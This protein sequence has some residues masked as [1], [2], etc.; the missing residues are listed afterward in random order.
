M[1]GENRNRNEG[2]VFQRTHRARVDD[3]DSRN[4]ALTQTPTCCRQDSHDV[5][6]A[7]TRTP[8]KEPAERIIRNVPK[9]Y[10]CVCGRFGFSA[11]P[12]AYGFEI[13]SYPLSYIPL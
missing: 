9:P 7:E 1:D 2:F 8:P 12:A 10:V 5:R 13:A 11:L 6:R 3:L 4:S